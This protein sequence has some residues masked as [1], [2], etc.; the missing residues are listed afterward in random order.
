MIL[1]DT[2]KNEILIQKNFLVVSTINTNF[3]HEIN[4][5]QNSFQAVSITFH[6]TLVLRYVKFRK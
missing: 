2:K 6:S 3:D 5:L 4:S 1:I